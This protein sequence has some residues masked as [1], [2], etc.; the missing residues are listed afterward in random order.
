MHYIC[1]NYPLAKF[2]ML[3]TCQAYNPANY[4]NYLKSG[5]PVPNQGG[6]YMNVPMVD[7]D[8][9][10]HDDKE[11]DKRVGDDDAWELWTTGQWKWTGRMLTS[12]QRSKSQGTRS[13]LTG[14]YGSDKHTLVAELPLFLGITILSRS[15]LFDLNFFKCRLFVN[16]IVCS[17]N[18]NSCLSVYRHHYTPIVV[19]R[20]H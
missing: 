1:R 16:I 2:V 19:N 20:M 4:S 3:A 5:M 8:H 17:R 9:P 14:G 11:F 15:F 13:P 12:G 10:D 6:G 7:V 18:N